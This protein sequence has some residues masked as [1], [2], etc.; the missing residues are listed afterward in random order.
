MTVAHQ[1]SLSMLSNYRTLSKQQRISNLFIAVLHKLSLVYVSY[2]LSTTFW[3][4]FNVLRLSFSFPSR[5]FYCVSGVLSTV[6]GITKSVCLSVRPSRCCI[7][8][9]QTVGNHAVLKQTVVQRL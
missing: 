7:I 2:Y 4:I 1:T 5:H 6:T 8:S 3:V 9:T